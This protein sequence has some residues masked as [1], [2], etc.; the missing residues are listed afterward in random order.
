MERVERSSH[1][2]LPARL[3]PPQHCAHL[4]MPAHGPFVLDL[5]SFSST[6]DPPI[7][8]PI[9]KLVQAIP[10]VRSAPGLACALA[11]TLVREFTWLAV[12]AFL[13]IG[14][15]LV[16]CNIRTQVA[17][18]KLQLGTLQAVFLHL[19]LVCGGA[20]Q[21]PCGDGLTSQRTMWLSGFRLDVVLHRIHLVVFLLFFH[22]LLR[23]FVLIFTKPVGFPQRAAKSSLS[24]GSLLSVGLQTYLDDLECHLTD[25]FFSHQL[26]PLVVLRWI[27]CSNLV[28]FCHVSQSKCTCKLAPPVASA[29]L[30]PQ[31]S[32]T[33]RHTLWRL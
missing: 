28:S 30:A 9:L 3:S 22:T 23:V 32:S 7:L 13:S 10:T 14:V 5:T 19:C 12:V 26:S 17:I 31:A 27:P 2:L 1:W 18:T 8:R 15:C 6:G 16:G 21:N 24:P 25:V 20:S 33:A 4:K 29:C 11:F